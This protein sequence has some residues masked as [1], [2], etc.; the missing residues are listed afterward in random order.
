MNFIVKDLSNLKNK[1]FIKKIS[2][3]LY[4]DNSSI[5]KTIIEFFLNSYFF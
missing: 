2:L 5:I 1:F 4:F 3:L